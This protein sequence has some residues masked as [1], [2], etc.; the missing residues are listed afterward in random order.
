MPRATR[1]RAARVRST[2][3]SRSTT[4]ERPRAFAKPAR[5][6]LRLRHP[7]G[8]EELGAMR[9]FRPDSPRLGHTL[10]TLE[11]GHPISWQVLGEQLARDEEGEPYLDLLGE[12][13]YAELE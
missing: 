5:Y 13:D 1:S 12:R 8:R 10:T 9:R 6:R 11:D 2:S 7:D 3:S 4:G